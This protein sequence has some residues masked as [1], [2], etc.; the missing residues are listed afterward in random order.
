MQ[1]IK[2]IRIYLVLFFVWVCYSV[3]AKISL[4]ECFTDRM[5]LQQQIDAPIWGKADPNQKVKVTTSWDKKTY[6][7]HADAEGKWIVNVATPQAGGPYSIVISDGRELKLNNVLIGEVWFCSGQSNMEMPLAG[8]GKIADYEAEIAAADFPDI[9]LLQ[10]QKATDTQPADQFTTDKG[11][12]QVCSTATIA[13]FSSVAYFFAR[14]LHRNLKVPIG[15]IHASWGGTIAEAWTSGRSLKEMPYFKETV[16]KME[17]YS[18]E[19]LIQAYTKQIEERNAKIASADKGIVN[20][21]PVW[22]AVEYPDTDWKEMPLPTL[23]EDSQL[24]NMD[25]IVWF[26][27][28]I[29]IPVSWAGKD[30]QLHF[31]AID[32]ND[33]TYFNG[34]EIGSKEGFDQPRNYTIPGKL[35]KA[36]KAVITVRVTDTGGGGG[37]YGNA[38][39][40]AIGLSG[41]SAGRIALAGNWK[42]EVTV[43]LKDFPAKPYSPYE[44]NRPTVLYNAMVYP[45]IPYGIQGAIWYQGEANVERAAQYKE[46]F[47]LLIRDWRQAW[48][49]NFP[50]YFV[51]L[52]NYMARTSTPQESVWAELREVQLQTLNLENTGMAVTIDIGDADDIHPKNKQEVGRRLALIARANTYSQPLP[53]SGPLYAG[54]TLEQ[55]QIRIH[56]ENAQGLRSSDGKSLTGFAIAGSDRRFHWAEAK[57]E[58]NEVV[59]SAPVVKYPVAVRYAWADNPACNL[60]NTGG[61]PASPF[62]TDNWT[63]T[64]P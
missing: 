58:G 9:R 1:S 54:Y 12:W 19:E 24:P 28:T 55:N 61:L 52:A 63:D 22:A 10:V 26:R 21:I 57:I 3:S 42:Y 17:T 45:L 13:E 64:L 51:Q 39:N 25:G 43:D 16:Q 62:R 41:N 60:T 36:G 50:F 59:I 20:H 34:Q 18:N 2:G 47:P 48:N 30:L 53:F 8:W 40:L 37:I 46:L 49:R 38:A 35:V 4:P 7:I 56:F 27:K 14:D 6:T 31:D 32:D 5:V 33:I 44:S 29:E 23:W 11:G 15:L